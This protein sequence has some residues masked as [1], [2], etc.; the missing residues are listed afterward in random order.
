MNRKE[1]DPLY[2][3]LAQRKRKAPSYNFWMTQRYHKQ[4][5]DA[6]QWG[7]EEMIAKARAHQGNFLLNLGPKPDGSLPEKR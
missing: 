2:E 5:Y 4:P 6:E 7:A 1:K 3:K